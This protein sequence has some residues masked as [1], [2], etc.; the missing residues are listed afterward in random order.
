MNG[1]WSQ[2]VRVPRRGVAKGASALS[3]RRLRGPPA[4]FG[5][6]DA[7]VALRGGAAAV[8]TREKVELRP[9]I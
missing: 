8:N 7:R 2:R 4:W 6:L 9:K 1:R 3:G 5:R